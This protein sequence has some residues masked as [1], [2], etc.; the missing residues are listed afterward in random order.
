M[1][2]MSHKLESQFPLVPTFLNFYL[3]VCLGTASSDDF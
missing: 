3:F 2:A 1:S